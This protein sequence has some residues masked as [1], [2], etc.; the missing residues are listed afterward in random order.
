MLAQVFAMRIFLVIALVP[1]LLLSGC[2]GWHCAEGEDEAACEKTCKEKTTQY[3]WHAEKGAEC[4]GDIKDQGACE[5]SRN[6][7]LWIDDGASAT[8]FQCQCTCKKKAKR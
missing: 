6:G 2:G 4:D 7:C 5:S 1:T 3:T 8:C